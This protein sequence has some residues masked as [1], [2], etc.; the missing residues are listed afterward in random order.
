M[1]VCSRRDLVWDDK[2]LRLHSIRGRVLAAIEPDREW[3]GMWR[4]RMPDGHLNDMLN[5]PRAKDAAASL[6]LTVLN[7]HREAA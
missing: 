6:T 5:L 7:K 3:P 4:V 1:R 2:Q